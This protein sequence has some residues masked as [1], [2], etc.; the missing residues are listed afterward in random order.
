[1]R[2]PLGNLKDISLELIFTSGQAALKIF[3]AV[4][5]APVLNDDAVLRIMYPMYSGSSMKRRKRQIPT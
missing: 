2:Q 5:K 4:S 3:L 1:M